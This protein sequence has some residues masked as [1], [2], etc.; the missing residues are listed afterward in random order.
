MG[1]RKSTLSKLT[2]LSFIG[3]KSRFLSNELVLGISLELL[4]NQYPSLTTINLSGN[5]IS[6]V[7]LLADALRKNA[8]VTWLNLSNNKIKNV[9]PLSRSL[10]VNNTLAKLF[11]SYNLIHNVKSLGEALEKNSFLTELELY[12]N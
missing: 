11:L 3:L 7:S 4:N 9:D 5:Q 12:G 6:N 8:T 10:Q 2:S 1:D